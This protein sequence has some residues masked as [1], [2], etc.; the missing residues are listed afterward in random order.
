MDPLRARPVVIGLYGLP[1]SGKTYLQNLLKASCPSAGFIFFEGSQVID[2]LVPGGI[3]AFRRLEEQEKYHW[4]EAAIHHILDDVERSGSAAIITGHCMFWDDDTRSAQPVV[5]AADL[6]TYT[7]IIYHHC[8]VEDIETRRQKDPERARPPLSRTILQQWQ[9]AEISYLRRE[10]YQHHILFTFTPPGTET[11]LVRLTA[12]M[13]GFA[14][15]TEASNLQRTLA[16]LD[17]MVSSRKDL[18]TAVMIDGDR[19][20]VEEDTGAMWWQALPAK[21]QSQHGARPL[22]DVFESPF[23][24]HHGAFRQTMLMYEHVANEEDFD[25]MCVSVAER[26][27]IRTEFLQLLRA[28]QSHEHVTVFL[29]SCGLHH[30]WKLLL[31]RWDLA[32]HVHIIALSLGDRGRVVTPK[33]K[34]E[35]VR[36]LRDVH[37]MHVWAFGDSPLDIP[38]LQEADQAV[39]VVGDESTRSKSMDGALQRSDLQA[40]QVVVPA[41]A[42]PRLTEAELP[43]I[44]FSDPP[45]IDFI[46]TPGAKLSSFAC[47]DATA[48]PAS[49][50]LATSM[51]D[52]RISGPDLRQAHQ[53]AGRYLALHYLSDSIG[54]ER[55]PVPHVQGGNT[56]GWTLRDASRT[57]IVAIMRGGEPMATGVNQVFR[58]AAMLHAREPGQIGSGDLRPHGTVILVDSVIN[59]GRSIVAFIRRV[60][61]MKKTIR[62]CI[63]TGVLQRDCLADDHDLARLLRESRATLI[64]LR[65]SQNSY[66]GT[67]QTDTGNRLFNTEYDE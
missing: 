39:V 16:A 44:S 23:A 31:E 27:T 38:M 28:L 24:Y 54:V 49:K 57:L 4:R 51:R 55:K 5:T 21:L 67:R 12:I 8:D 40:V 14:A 60:R 47:I 62:I 53:D 50:L 66:V 33:V 63:V 42:R 10:C 6:A 13:Q 65:T 17:Q 22:A 29:I 19:T 41:S 58:Q 48:T 15:H 52:A 64:S 20:L 32:E 25:A 30:V 36:R 7:H 43:W 18:S 2:S 35:V 3:A 45:L 1:G 61:E 34:Q 11:F 59:S 56:D 46:T 37:A 26:V 9:Q